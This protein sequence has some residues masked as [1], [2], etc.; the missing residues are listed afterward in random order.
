MRI[1]RR[2]RAV[3][4]LLLALLALAAPGADARLVS[5]YRGAAPP[6]PGT[7]HIA[8]TAPLRA[9]AIAEDARHWTTDGLGAYLA[10][11]D[12]AVRARAARAVGRL[13]DSTAVPALLPLLA[14]RDPRVAHEAAF[15]LGQI[16]HPSAAAPLAAVTTSADAGLRAL[17]IEALGK[18]G[19]KAQTPVVVRALDD[20]L[21]A[22][23]GAAAVA[24]WRLADS[25][26]VDAL[27]AHDDDP[28]AGVRW[29]V[30]W[31]L[32][33]VPA[34][35][36]VVLR[37]ALHV[38]DP[39]ATVRARA[40]RTIGRQK[41][42]RGTAYLFAALAD[43]DVGVV[44][45]A[46]RALQQIADTATVAAGPAL[47]HGLAHAHP[48]V[49]VTAATALGERFAWVAGDSAER[50]RLADALA[51]RLAD[52]DAATRGAAA[53]ALLARR[54]AAALPLVRPLLADSVVY[55]RVAVLEGLR[56]LPGD[57]DAAAL[58]AGRLA[59]PAT[60]FE[61]ATA[62]DVLGERKDTSAAAAL[63]AGLRDT[64]WLFAASCAGALGAI[65]DVSAVP[66]LLAAYAA[67]HGDT[68]PDAR[69]AIVDALRTL[70]RAHAADSLE[71]AFAPR[72]PSPADHDD[73]FFTVPAERGA[74]IHTSKGDIEWAFDAAEAPQTV[75]NFVRL[76]RRGFFDGDR[77]HR[78]VPDFVIQ[79]G[80]PTGT[81]SGGPGYSIRCEY[82]MLRYDAGMVG[83]AL[84]GKDTGGSQWFITH[85][86]QP[87]LDG[88]YTIFA[89]V[90][91]GMDVVDRIVQGDRIE[92]VE[93][94][95]GP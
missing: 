74:V 17:A 95:G 45:E 23:R 56:A 15:A 86:P 78:V 87:H 53:K 7:L 4:A 71:H 16:G 31:A 72:Q 57:D 75:R 39:D 85:S 70:G 46:I 33:K 48:Y 22:V 52:P 63:T 29:R 38:G 91:R 42:A 3:P 84:S 80:D 93:I 62:A 9:I 90:V 35:D 81:G 76:A 43:A 27:V 6:H 20:P 19:A 54:G 82:N 67:H 83:M 60:V 68:E 24:L 10:H 40:V 88:R 30:L 79:D 14:D 69:L 44:V 49:R 64:S 61:R 59:P 1:D 21:P 5:A 8:D 37:A 73:A 51:A 26:A 11:T 25:T 2:A 28:D 92:R 18:V 55:V 36:R 34:A 66:R 41:S 50:V 13:Q 58:L 32:E 65:G 77:V 89:H 47:E 94:L 12:P